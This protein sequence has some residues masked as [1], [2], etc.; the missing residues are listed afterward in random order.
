MM[1]GVTLRN[2]QVPGIILAQSVTRKPFPY[3][4]LCTNYLFILILRVRLCNTLQGFYLHRSDPDATFMYKYL[5]TGYQQ[6][7]CRND[8]YRMISCSTALDLYES[9]HTYMYTIM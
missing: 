9:R 7:Q 8:T 2:I 1:L 5:C 3:V 6:D 4:M